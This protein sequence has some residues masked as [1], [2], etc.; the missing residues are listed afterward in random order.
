[1]AN[2]RLRT[3]P[4]CAT[5]VDSTAHL[6]LRDYNWLAPRMPGREAPMDL[7]FVIEKGGHILIMENKPAA[8]RAAG[9]PLGQKITLQAF[10]RLGCEVW[11]VWEHE[12]GVIVDVS[13][14]G[15]TK[16]ET[17][18]V[19]ELGTRALAWRAQYA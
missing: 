5:P 13:E 11:V 8:M 17:I 7:D 15:E 3:C 19:E 14:L 16:T 9:I 1:M 2:A 6:G 18:T 12:D 4:T 10:Q